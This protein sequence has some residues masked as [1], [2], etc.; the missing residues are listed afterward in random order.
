M[1]IAIFELEYSDLN[2]ISQ[3][4]ANSIEKQSYVNTSDSM[5]IIATEQY[6]LRTNSAQWN[7]VVLKKEGHKIRVDII[8]A[9]GG[10]GIFNI[11]L[12]AESSFVK[13]LGGR[14]QAFC[15]NEKIGLLRIE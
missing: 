15:A 3:V 11:S 14:L 6:K 2:R 8:G 12:W 4:F 9:A 13:R 7:M 5:T 10:T 1:K